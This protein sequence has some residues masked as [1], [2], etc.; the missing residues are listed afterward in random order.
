MLIFCQL[1]SFK[2]Q[3]SCTAGMPLSL[4]TFGRSARDAPSWGPDSIWR[5]VLGRRLIPYIPIP[6]DIMHAVC[7]RHVMWGFLNLKNVSATL[8]FL[9]TCDGTPNAIDIRKNITSMT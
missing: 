6:V 4:F 5:L 3:N 8:L 9:K 2:S 7:L 1:F